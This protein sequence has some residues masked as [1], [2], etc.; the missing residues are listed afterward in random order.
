[1]KLYGKIIK[2]KKIIKEASVENNDEKLN[3]RDAL[4]HCL[5]SLCRELDVQVPMWLR[6]NTAEFVNYRRTF[7]TE[8]HF[9]EKISFDKLEIKVE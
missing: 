7:F 9:V 6:N 8:E 2:N 5:I 4:E 3:Y 1:M